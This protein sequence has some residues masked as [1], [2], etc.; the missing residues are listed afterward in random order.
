[1]E[2]DDEHEKHFFESLRTLGWIRRGA[3]LTEPLGRAIH[4]IILSQVKNTIQGEFEEE[5]LLDP[6]KPGKTLLWCVGLCTC[7]AVL[8]VG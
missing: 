8:F 7:I 5:T 2:E 1:M 3:C 6:Y 4:D